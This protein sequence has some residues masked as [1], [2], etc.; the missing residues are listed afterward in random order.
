MYIN[1]TGYYIPETRI[2]NNYFTGINGLTDEWISQRTGICTRAWAKPEETMDA[3]CI[4]AVRNALAHLPYHISDVDLI[5]FASYT[6][7]DTV[8]TTAHVIQRE[9]NISKAKAFFLSSACSSAMNAL[10]IVQLFFAGKKASK[11]LLVSADRNTTYI[12]KTDPSNGH[13]WGDAAA[14]FF[15]SNECIGHNEPQVIDVTTQGLGHAGKGPQGVYLNPKEGAIRM[16]YGKDVFTQACQCIASNTRDI[17]KLNGYQLD[18]LSYFIGHQ[19]NMRIISHVIKEL[20]IPEE[21]SL[22][23]ISELGNT[24]SV[25]SMLLLAQNYARFKPDDLVCLS[26]FGGGYSAG[27]CLIRF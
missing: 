2:P 12:D 19:A 23:N 7:S 11:A 17:V 6:P 27:A 21:K 3:M 1:A 24:G 18:D 25:S 20:G 10:E 15:F 5:I 13:L 9:F 14:A 26:V 22:N 8:A 4:S 16:P